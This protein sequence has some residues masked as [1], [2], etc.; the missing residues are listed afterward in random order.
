MVNDRRSIRSGSSEPMVNQSIP[1]NQSIRMQQVKNHQRIMNIKI[2][3]NIL[4]YKL[5]ET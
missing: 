3:I 2:Y 4:G 1:I 5:Q